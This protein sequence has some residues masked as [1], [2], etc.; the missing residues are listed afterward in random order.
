MSVIRI[1]ILAIELNFTKM[2]GA[3]FFFLL[4]WVFIFY[5]KF[6]KPN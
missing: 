4:N 1:Y 6:Y 2:V 3:Y 5:M